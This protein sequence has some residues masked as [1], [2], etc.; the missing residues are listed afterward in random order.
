MLLAMRRASSATGREQLTASRLGLRKVRPRICP[1]SGTYSGGG[2]AGSTETIPSEPRLP[3]PRVRASTL[4]SGHPSGNGGRA[5]LEAQVL[6][7]GLRPAPRREMAYRERRAADHG[8][9]RAVV[10]TSSS[11]NS[12]RAVWFSQRPHRSP[13]RSAISSSSIAASTASASFVESVPARNAASVASRSIRAFSSRESILSR[14][15]LLGG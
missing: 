4:Q 2:G 9:R 1:S 3:Q 5:A 12:F 15:Y 7:R 10:R 14:S 13:T 6:L 11:R 8:K